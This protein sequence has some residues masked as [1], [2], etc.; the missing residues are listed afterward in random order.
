MPV[1]SN[2]EVLVK[3]HSASINPL[4]IWMSRGYGGKLFSNQGISPPYIV[5]IFAT[6]NI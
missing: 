2:G 4:D 6:L 1:P 5:G 3:I